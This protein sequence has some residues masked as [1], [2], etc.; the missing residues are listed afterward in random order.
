VVRS[1]SLKSLIPSVLGCESYLRM[2]RVHVSNYRHAVF[3][4]GIAECFVEPPVVLEG[5]VPRAQELEAVAAAGAAAQRRLH[6]RRRG[7]GQA[8][9]HAGR[10]GPSQQQ[11]HARPLRR[12]TKDAVHARQEGRQRLRGLPNTQTRVRNAFAFLTG[13]QVSLY[14]GLSNLAQ[15]RGVS[16]DP[17][18]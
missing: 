8:Q 17:T 4:E 14:A 18:I 1:K 9:R 16:I 11:Q 13:V 5:G 12:R 2:K 6:G 7:A 3:R 10:P 15:K